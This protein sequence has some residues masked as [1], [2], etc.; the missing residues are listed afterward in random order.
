MYYTI[1]PVNMF[2]TS[3]GVHGRARNT[4]VPRPRYFDTFTSLSLRSI[5]SVGFPEKSRR[6]CSYIVDDD[7]ARKESRESV[8]LSI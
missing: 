4:F 3:D 7:N 2:R 1:L 6:Y 5:Y 8:L